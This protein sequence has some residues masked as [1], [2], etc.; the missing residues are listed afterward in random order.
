MNGIVI[1]T[2]ILAMA[3]FAYSDNAEWQIVEVNTEPLTLETNDGT[4][5]VKVNI[6]IRNISRREMFIWGANLGGEHNLYQIHSFVKDDKSGEWEKRNM[7]IGGLHGK[8]KWIRVDPGETISVTKFFS[9]KYIGWQMILKFLRAYGGVDT[10]GSEI[11]LGPIEIP[12]V[13]KIER[14]PSGDRQQA[15]SATKPAL[16]WKDSETNR[17]VFTSDDIIKFDWDIQMFQLTEDAVVEFCGDTIGCS[18]PGMIVEDESGPIYET[19]WYNPLLSYGCSYNPIYKLWENLHF[20]RQSTFFPFISIEKGRPGWKNSPEEDKDRRFDPRLKAGLEKAG[21]LGSINLDS[22]YVELISIFTGSE[23]KVVGEDLKVWVTTGS[24]RLN[25]NAG[26]NIFFRGGEKTLQKVDSFAM[27]IKLIANNGSFRSET[28]IDSEAVDAFKDGRYACEFAPWQP[29]A[30][31]D[32]Y[33]EMGPGFV[34]LALLFSKNGKIIYRL[35]IPEKS[36]L[37]YQ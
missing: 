28:R 10:Q 11:L 6:G 30:G 22:L 3:R 17:V 33:P 12:E 7:E 1:L 25:R 9:E 24:F 36:V 23:P 26:L 31:S 37:I 2:L 5:S 4:S 32:K 18:S 21:V 29:V 27:D 20:F 19:C 14:P 16:L 13:E 34:S 15:V 35:E 8:I